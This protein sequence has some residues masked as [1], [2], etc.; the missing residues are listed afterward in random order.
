M[1]PDNEGAIYV[2]ILE[3]CTGGGRQ[4]LKLDSC[5][6]KARDIPEE[7]REK[8]TQAVYHAVL[9]MGILVALFGIGV[10][11]ILPT[12]TVS[13]LADAHHADGVGAVRRC[14]PTQ[15]S[16]GAAEGIWRKEQVAHDRLWQAV[17]RRRTQFGRCATTKVRSLDKPLQLGVHQPYYRAVLANLVNSGYSMS[18]NFAI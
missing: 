4:R 14:M 5:L 15:A 3:E 6:L 17:Q 12:A 18:K 9:A 7:A 13:M 2:S 16:G 1:R 11:Y 8:R 10:D